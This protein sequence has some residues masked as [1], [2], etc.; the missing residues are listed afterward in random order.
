MRWLGLRVD[1]IFFTI[2]VAGL[3]GSCDSAPSRNE[4]PPAPDPAAAMDRRVREAVAST[5]R[6]PSSAQF[7]RV[8]RIP[9]IRES[10]GEPMGS[11]RHYCGEVNGRNAFGAYAGFQ[12]FHSYDPQGQPQ[13][14]AVS[15][16]D[17]SVPGSSMA[18]DINC[19]DERGREVPGEPVNF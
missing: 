16:S 1:L 11:A 10:N 5:L 2:V 18:Y 13:G 3:S 17:P 6:D 19:K 4:A 7:R 14:E 12:P 8:R 9:V 15:I